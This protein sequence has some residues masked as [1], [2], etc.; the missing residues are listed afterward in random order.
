MM[1]F[2]CD[3]ARMTRTG[4]ILRVSGGNRI[5]KKYYYLEKPNHSALKL[6]NDEH[7][8]AD[9]TVSYWI[10]CGTCM[11]GCYYTTC[12]RQTC[13]SKCVPYGTRKQHSVI[14][15]CANTP[16][17][18]SCPPQRP[19]PDVQA[20]C[21]HYYC[22]FSSKSLRRYKPGHMNFTLPTPWWKSWSHPRA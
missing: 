20:N 18:T 11:R 5:Y 10:R 8:T 9:N 16:T 12:T 1:H 14:R 4:Y 17:S 21:K 2:P 22:G 13:V 3:I 15:S 6:E 19:C 7:D